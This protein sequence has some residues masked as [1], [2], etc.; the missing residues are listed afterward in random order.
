VAPT[1]TSSSAVRARSPLFSAV[2]GLAGLAILLQGVW[3]GLFIDE[4]HDF[5]ENWVN[6][7]SIGGTVIDVL[8]LI[9]MIIAIWQLRA[10][11]DILVGSIVFFVLV[12]IETLLGGFIGDTPGL[13]ALHIPLALF[14]MGM[15]AVL[16]FRASRP[17]A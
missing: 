1:D 17:A 16:S 14:L 3:A 5:R 15:V 2:I 8:A 11:R 9:A 12:V 7:H 10:R 13:A 4:G 6:V